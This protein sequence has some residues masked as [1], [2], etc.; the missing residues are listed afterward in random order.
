MSKLGWGGVGLAV[1]IVMNTA[2]AEA[3]TEEP[4]PP[5]EPAPSAAPLAEPPPP[6][7]ETKE[8]APPPPPV[9]DKPP[10]PE[11][12]G[13][14]PPARRGLQ[15]AADLGYAMPLGRLE[16]GT[17]QVGD[18]NIRQSNDL[19]RLFGAQ[20]MLTF[21][22]G[23]KVQDHIYVGGYL[24]GSFGGVGTDFTSLCDRSDVKCFTDVFRLGFAFKAH[25]LPAS[26]VNPWLGV[27]LGY[28]G[29]GLTAKGPN[30]EMS[31]TASGVE[32]PLSLGADI[33]LSKHIGIG[34]KVDLT[35]AQYGHAELQ[36]VDGKVTSSSVDDK[37]IHSWLNVGARAVFF[38]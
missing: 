2:H 11:D 16:G 5:V 6:Q 1:A 17:S 13:G 34:P 36:G 23:A 33:R 10:Q 4:P 26:F 35:V 38:P 3:Q 21:E 18:S 29:A 20:G 14:A 28:E 27:G 24:A 22:V 30:G 37:D 7:P 32:L 25:L 15:V 31:L 12:T 19:A 9:V 8:V